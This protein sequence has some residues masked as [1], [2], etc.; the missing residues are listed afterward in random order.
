MGIDRFKAIRK[1]LSLSEHWEYLGQLHHKKN[2]NWY[3]AYSDHYNYPGSLTVMVVRLMGGQFGAPSGT[4]QPRDIFQITQLYGP[5]H[6]TQAWID[7]K[8][9]LTKKSIADCLMESHTKDGVTDFVDLIYESEE[10]A[11]SIVNDIPGW[12]P[13][14]FTFSDG[15]VLEI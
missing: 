1:Y 6:S 14:E 11:V 2:R 7:D 9:A 8:T 13:T 5:L 12:N 4:A 10:K 15:S 3:L